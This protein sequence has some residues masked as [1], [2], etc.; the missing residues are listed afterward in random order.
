MF[1]LLALPPAFL[2]LL[3]FQGAELPQPADGARIFQ[4]NCAS[5]HR[6]ERDSPAPLP[7]Q[8]RRMSRESILRSLET[9]K[10]KEQGTHLT[11]AERA[12]VAE[13]LGAPSGGAAGAVSAPCAP[14][15]FSTASDPSW[16]G[17]GVDP[18]NS[19]F[20]PA[21]SARLGR[22]E[23]PRL[24]LKWA[25][26]YPGASATFGQPTV[27]GGRLFVG[28]ED[29]TVYSL[30]ARTGCVYWTFKAPVTVKTAVSIDGGGHI[31]YF[32]DTV[33]TVYAVDAEKGS[34]LWKFRVE[35]HSAARITGSPLLIHG[36]L[37][38]PVSSGEEGA[39]VDP[40]YPC[41]TFRGSVVALDARTGARIWKSYTI[42]QS[43][44]PTG[45][46]N[47]AGTELWGPAGA[48]VWSPPT[49]DLKARAIYVATGNSYSEPDT[50]YADAVIAFDMG[51]G[52]MPWWHQ[53]TANDLWNISC[54]APD[55]ANCPERPGRDLD[56]G[57]P[58]I[59]RSLPDGR[60]ILIVGQKSGVVHALDP[61]HR[62]KVLWEKRIGVG[63]PLGGIQWGG[64]V[65]ENN[66][67]YYARSDWDEAGPDVG[68]G[69]FALRI[70]SG[71]RIWFAPPAKPACADQPGCSAAQ[72]APVTA[73]PGVVFSGSLDG[74]LRGYDTRDGRVIWDFDALREFAT[75]N[76]APA[77]GGSFNASGP[78][79]V[80]GMLYA[81]SGY[82][83]AISGNVL[84]AFSVDGK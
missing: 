46:R 61:D 34:L 49:A 29:G 63:G 70:A 11:A 47:S 55:R 21:A 16:T 76:G 75:V 26:G 39:A 48:A 45:R 18:S 24:Q 57:S 6:A 84:L 40:K 41:C 25:F 36:R 43:P 74:H 65:G 5:C 22:E 27:A 79:I 4:G 1:K 73:I 71:E 10:M 3:A 42:P 81:N 35:E 83:N 19:R 68:G 20:Q 38:V 7:E 31:A 52:K 67:V 59:L 30:D 32:G 23:V 62:G 50:P 9:G 28:S 64:A 72:M 37:Y 17:W 58:P 51:S 12:A 54:V 33:G 8:L 56:F 66:A 82:T 80:D 44:K 2:L 69:L 13:Y 60:R 53:F 15:P 78:A 14:K 77:K